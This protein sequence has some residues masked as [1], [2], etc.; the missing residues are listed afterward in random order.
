[1]SV[2]DRDE[3]IK[4]LLAESFGLRTRAEQLSQYVES[5]VAELVKTKKTLAE[6][7]NGEVVRKLNDELQAL[8]HG[9]EEV[10]HQRN[11]LQSRL[12]S[13]IKEHDQLSNSHMAMTDQRDR[14]RDRMAAVEA[15]KEYR[16]AQR[17]VRLFPFLK[18]QP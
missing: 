18:N 2:D 1:M 6:H 15:A 14:L 16:L 7:E 10:T 11:E 17:I 4:E 3:L 5:R 13:L 8:R 9:L 12:D